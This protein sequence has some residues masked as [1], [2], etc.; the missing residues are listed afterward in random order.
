MSKDSSSELKEAEAVLNEAVIE[1]RLPVHDSAEIRASIV[2]QAAA[3]RNIDS[4]RSIFDKVCRK[5]SQLWSFG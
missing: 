4:K 3:L 2:R 1:E 5:T